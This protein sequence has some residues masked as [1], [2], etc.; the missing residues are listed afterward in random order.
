MAVRPRLLVTVFRVCC[1]RCVCV[2]DLVAHVSGPND[3]G[4]SVVILVR[5]QGF[6]FTAVTDHACVPISVRLTVV[7]ELVR[8]LTAARVNEGVLTQFQ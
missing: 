2:A 4:F 7:T 5:S 8:V 6:V 1:R 3:C